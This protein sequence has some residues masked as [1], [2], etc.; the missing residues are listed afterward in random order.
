MDGARDGSETSREELVVIVGRD[1]QSDRKMKRQKDKERRE[2]VRK[3][4]ATVEGNSSGYK[5]MH[6]FS[7]SDAESIT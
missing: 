4:R 2:R 1:M 5:S 3:R 6:Y 7:L